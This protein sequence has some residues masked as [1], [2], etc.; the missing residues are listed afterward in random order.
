MPTKLYNIKEVMEKENEYKNKREI[1][2]CLKY[3][4]ILY[5]TRYYEGTFLILSL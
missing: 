2:K 1:N 3:S 4:T 5:M